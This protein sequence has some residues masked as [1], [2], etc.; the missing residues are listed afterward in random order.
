MLVG[1]VLGPVV[2]GWAAEPAGAWPKT[3]GE[4]NKPMR[5]MDAMEIRKCTCQ[6]SLQGD[7]WAVEF[8]LNGLFG[9]HSIVFHVSNADLC[10]SPHCF[11]GD[12][13]NSGIPRK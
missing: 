5:A 1:P 10:K 9:K 11:I 6:H 4:A 12:S 2:A 8:D 3:D 13:D 7:L